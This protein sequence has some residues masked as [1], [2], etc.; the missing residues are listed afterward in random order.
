MRQFGTAHAAAEGPRFYSVAQVATLFGT[1]A[2]TIYRAIEAGEFP[3]IRIRTRLIVPA[4]A[5]EAMANAATGRGIVD[6]ADF[7]PEA[8]A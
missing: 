4:R 2:M 8:T 5:V 6:S 1:S 3:A 7:V